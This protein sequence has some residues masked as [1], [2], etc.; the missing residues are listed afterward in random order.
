V[1]DA[2]DNDFGRDNAARSNA[3]T[4]NGLVGVV[5]GLL[6]ERVSMRFIAQVTEERRAMRGRA[7]HL[8]DRIQ[9][10]EQMTY[11]EIF[12]YGT[13]DVAH[14]PPELDPLSALLRLK[15]TLLVPVP[16]QLRDANT[17]DRS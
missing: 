1:D 16:M 17:K 9:P 13:A 10:W 12:V 5:L 15:L 11:P 8:P 3:H 2:D 6:K 7:P 4:G 14:Q